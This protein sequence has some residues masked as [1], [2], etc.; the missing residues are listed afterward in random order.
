MLHCRMLPLDDFK[1]FLYCKKFAIITLV[2]ARLLKCQ[3]C[4]VS[5]ICSYLKKPHLKPSWQR[6]RGCLGSVC[7]QLDLL[8]EKFK[9]N[10]YLGNTAPKAWITMT[11]DPHKKQATLSS[12]SAT[13][14]PKTCLFIVIQQQTM[15]SVQYQL[16]IWTMQGNQKAQIMI[17]KCVGV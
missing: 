8:L 1:R 12:W 4:R 6:H 17:G 16:M 7:G 15:N 5:D 10:D 2:N 14:Q 9:G 11:T 3:L 13:I